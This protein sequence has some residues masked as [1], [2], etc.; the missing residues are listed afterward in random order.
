MYDII[1]LIKGNGF[2]FV[3]MRAVLANKGKQ[4]HLK[5]WETTS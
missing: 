5:L 4:T 2:K 1:I 3:N